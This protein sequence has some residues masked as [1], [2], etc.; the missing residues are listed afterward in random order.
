[1]G[2]SIMITITT[3]VAVNRLERQS[4]SAPGSCEKDP[5]HKT[6]FLGHRQKGEIC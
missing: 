5:F 6:S 2:V 3:A 1:M 4:A